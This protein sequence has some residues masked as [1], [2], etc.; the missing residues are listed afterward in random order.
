MVVGG[1]SRTATPQRCSVGARSPA[2]QRSTAPG[3]AEHTPSPAAGF[4][5]EPAARLG[6][7]HVS[8]RHGQ[9]TMHV[10]INKLIERDLQHARVQV[11]AAA[12]DAH[13]NLRHTSS[14]AAL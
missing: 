8:D 7:G 3:H 2:S 4:E 9:Q 6:G 1:I 13:G 11:V 14:R 10:E 5:P 12:T